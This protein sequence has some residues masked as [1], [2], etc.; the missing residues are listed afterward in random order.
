MT[1]SASWPRLQALFDEALDWPADARERRLADRCRGEPELL[2]QVLDLLAAHGEP[3]PLDA[4]VQVREPD[5]V[6]PLPLPPGTR[7]GAWQ[8]GERLGRG[9][10][11]EVY[12]AERA[13]G[14]VRQRTAIKVLKRGLDTDALLARFLRER[15]I[16]AR[17]SHPH[18]ARLLDAGATADGLPWLAMER[19]DGEPLDAWVQRRALPPD[20]RLRLMQ[21]VC[22]TVHEAHRNLVVHRD[23]KPA[24]VLVTADGQ[25]KL[26]D[27]GIAKLLDED[28]PDATRLSGAALPMTPA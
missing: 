10:M 3:G 27:F 2:Q 9:G 17:L 7:L 21:T 5:R 25:V 24:N 26:L 6:D 22:E 20:A 12:A 19:I 15:S 18:I 28:A 4:P 11:G 1:D 16:L 13:D 8:L 14:M 23:L